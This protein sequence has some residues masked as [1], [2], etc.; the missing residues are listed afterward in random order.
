MSTAPG[1]ETHP[2]YKWYIL[3]LTALTGAFAMAAPYMS[4]SV[5]FKEISADL[6][7]SLVQIGLVWSIGSLPAMFMSILSGVINDRIGPKYVIITASLLLGFAGAARGLATSFSTLLIPIL[8]L[9]VLT[10]MIS[11][12]AFKICGMWFPGRQL[13]F[14]NGVF[15][16][17]MALGFLLSSLL[18]ATVL[19]PWLG[20][21]RN[22]L[23]FYGVLTILLCIPWI[24][25]RPTPL[26][27]RESSLAVVSVPMRQALL[28]VV[29]VVNLWLLSIAWM[30]L[31]GC[32]QGVTGYLPLYLRGLGW[33]AFQA[34]GAL[35]LFHA[36]SMLFV[37]PLA[38]MSDRLRARKPLLAAMMGVIILGCGLL[39]TAQDK[40][41]WG[42][43]PLMGMV[44]DASV[45]LLITMIIE[46][47]GIGARYAGSATGFSLVFLSIGGLLSP[48]L[49]NRLAE[50]NPSLPFIFWAGLA[51]IGLFSLLLIKMP[52][53][54][55]VLA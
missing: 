18:S 4:L 35:S 20:G 32:M 25:A 26:A 1:I 21:W 44:R 43:I 51:A 50:Y 30:G 52:K 42:A 37:L 3:V 9:G 38:L 34:D 22:V 29:K 24:F 46:T 39:A 55:H 16:M 8:V 6:Q 41:I 40:L 10:P 12:S 23:F 15:S 31:S 19:S 2:N 53:R 48:P 28:H 54:R 49:G 17:G 45:A 47:E 14:A 13:A 36:V 7:L 33:P 5:L 11:T 27:L